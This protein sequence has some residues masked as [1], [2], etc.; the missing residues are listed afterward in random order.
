[1]NLENAAVPSSVSLSGWERAE[2]EKGAP[3]TGVCESVCSFVFFHFLTDTRICM[4]NIYISRSSTQPTLLAC[5]REKGV[6]DDGAK[7]AYEVSALRRSTKPKRKRIREEPEGKK[8][9]RKTV[10]LTGT[11]HPPHIPP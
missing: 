7:R 3:S 9:R 10:R 8:R 2:K 1:M 5:D 11:Y 6:L 4:K